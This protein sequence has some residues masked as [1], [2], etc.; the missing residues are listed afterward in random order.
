MARRD[1]RIKRYRFRLVARDPGEK[2]QKGNAII[3][4]MILGAKKIVKERLDK[5]LS[6]VEKECFT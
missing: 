5:S 2:E 1:I 3:E 6:K 4:P